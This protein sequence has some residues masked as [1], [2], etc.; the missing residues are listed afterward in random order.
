MDK[1]GKDIKPVSG[2]DGKVIVEH[3]APGNYQ[4]KETKAPVGYLINQ[5]SIPFT[6]V[7]E[8]EAK[9]KVVE[10]ADFK[11]YQGTIQLTKVDVEDPGKLLSGAVFNVTD[12]TGE[13]VKE[14]IVTNEKGQL[15]VDKLAPGTYY[16]VETKAPTGYQLST[17]KYEVTIPNQAL[18]EPQAIAVTIK[19]ER[20]KTATPSATNG[21]TDSSQFPQA[22]EK[23]NRMFRLLGVL[24][25]CLAGL[26]LFSKNNRKMTK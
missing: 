5:K 16:F 26:F 23:S 2:E 19:N 21:K 8:A 22:G 20:I 6:I 25:I 17:K 10:L 11:N 14:Q 7:Q 4:L 24:A 15:K 12:G 18:E 1:A 9:P 3:L 13:I